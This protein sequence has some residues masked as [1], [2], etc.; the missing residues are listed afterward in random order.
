MTE[1]GLINGNAVIGQSGGP[2]AVIN[3]SLVGC[4]EVLKE[5]AHVDKIYGAH[6]AVDGIIKGDF[7]ELQ[8]L[9][10]DRLDRLANT[11]SS[12]LG[13]SR[14]KPKAEH[15]HQMF[16]QLK[17]F[18][19]RYFFYIGGNDSSDTCRIINEDA[20][21]KGYELRCFHIP[22]TID[23]DLQ[24]NDHTP[25]FGSAARY[26]ACGFMGDNLDN[27]ALPGIKI[28]VVMGRHAGF[29]TAA[30]MLARQQPG[31]GPHLIYV[32]EAAFDSDKFLDDVNEMYD[33]HGR[34]LIAVSEGI[35]DADGTPVAVKLAVEQG[36]H[37]EKDSH[38][39]VQLSGT[40]ALGDFLAIHIKNKLGERR[41][42]KLRVRADT[43][44]YMQRCFAGC[45]S[46]TDQREARMAG[47]KAA[48][49]ALL[50]DLDGS[51][52][53]Q[54]AS[55]DPYK[56]EYTLVKLTDVAAKTKHLDEKYIVDGRD[57]HDSFRTYLAPLVGPLP[58][59]EQV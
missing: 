31:D 43:F 36:H 2:T 12:G 40:G 33:K 44:G 10:Q 13:S 47:R 32:P 42:E 19:V 14:L 16:E 30:S 5:S 34:C 8:D 56:V 26:V 7:I 37:V 24:C 52:A 49:V 53:I 50:G 6:H 45:V 28:N 25:G 22:K 39:N 15:C 18:N 48:E 11:P 20:R 21:S 23:N 57:I 35:S 1:T 58:V 3:Q 27:K 54:R 55:D 9:P 51:I 17:K 41:G 59:V 29:L 4:V 38:G 46:E